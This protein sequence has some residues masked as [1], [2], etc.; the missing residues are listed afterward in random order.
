MTVMSTPAC[1]RRIAAVSKH[2]RRD[3]FLAQRRATDCRV[4]RVDGEA[5]FERVSA[6]RRPVWVGKS[7]ASGCP[8]AFSQPR[9]QHRHDRFGERCDPVLA[10]FAQTAHVSADLEMQIEV[11]EANQL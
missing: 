4:R 1:S 8:G 9:L 5:T 11:A 2:V 10:S 3:D 6:E 7:G